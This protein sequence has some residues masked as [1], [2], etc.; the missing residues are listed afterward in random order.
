MLNAHSD[1]VLF[2]LPPLGAD[3]QWLRVLD[4]VDPELPERAFKPGFRYP[5][6]GRSVAVFKVTPPVRERR[7]TWTAAH[8]AAPEPIGAET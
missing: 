6:T 5:L 3:Q 2:T 8:A 4:T 7:R 1:K